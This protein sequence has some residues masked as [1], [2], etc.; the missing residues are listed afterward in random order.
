MHKIRKWMKKKGPLKYSRK[1]IP[2]VK[3]IESLLQNS[4]WPSATNPSLNQKLRSKELLIRPTIKLQLE[5]NKI[6]SSKIEWSQKEISLREAWSSS[7][8]SYIKD[9]DLQR[10]LDSSKFYK[11]LN[12]LLQYKPKGTFVKG[13]T[14]QDEVILGDQMQDYVQQYFTKPFYSDSKTSELPNNGIF[15]FSVDLERAFESVAKNKAV[16]FDNLL[17]D[18]FRINDHFSSYLR[19]WRVPSYFMRG[20]LILL[21]KDKSEFPTIDRTRPITVLPAITKLFESSILHNLEKSTNSTFFSKVQR[22][23][24]KGR[25]ILHNINDLLRECKR[26]QTERITNKELTPW[27]VFFDRAKAY[28]W[29]PRNLMLQ[30]LLQLYLP[31]NVV[32]T[33]R[34]MLDNFSLCCGGRNPAEKR[35]CARVSPITNVIQFVHQWSTSIN[36]ATKHKTL[37]LRGRYCMHMQ[38]NNS[39]KTSN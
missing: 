4:D 24:M 14:V 6:F 20:R 34:N 1:T 17:G 8:K 16:G 12:S 37:S 29:V 2:T 13:I 39:G 38:Y 31:F 22:G 7:F 15:N 28:D 30:K 35:T 25:S 9:L 32:E 10:R 33:I 27:V 5:A 19:T 11:I 21:S 3:G 36:G 23:F 18:I 26:L